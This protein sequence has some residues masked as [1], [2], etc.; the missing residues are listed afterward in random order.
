VRRLN[1][2]DRVH[3]RV[4]VIEF[5]LPLA[6]PFTADAAPW[7]VNWPYDYRAYAGARASVF[8]SR[9]VSAEN[10]TTINWNQVANTAQFPVVGA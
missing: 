7:A 6:G 2:L 5:P 10:A 3:H 9:A 1:K 4:S 8:L